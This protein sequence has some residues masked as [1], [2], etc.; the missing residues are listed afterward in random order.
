MNPL[1]HFYNDITT[2]DAVY[3]YIEKTLDEHAL[4]Q[5]YN[6]EDVSGIKDAKE[7]LLKSK[8]KMGLEFGEK[9]PNKSQNRAV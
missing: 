7:A 1:T 8:S 2:R 5:M 9:K 3:D 6:G 4:K